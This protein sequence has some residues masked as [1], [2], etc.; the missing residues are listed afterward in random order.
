MG[1]ATTKCFNMN[2]K[3]MQVEHEVIL[4]C[5]VDTV[6]DQQN[7]MFGLYSEYVSKKEGAYCN[8]NKDMNSLTKE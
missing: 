5:P 2:L 6:I 3:Q 4:E 7:A 8:L 1:G